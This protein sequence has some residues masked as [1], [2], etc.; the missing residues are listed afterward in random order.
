MGTDELSIAN[1]FEHL[2]SKGQ[3]VGDDPNS[4]AYDGWRQKKWSDGASVRYGVDVKW[5][6]GD[7]VGCA[8]DLEQGEIRFYLNGND[9]DTWS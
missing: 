5:K 3:D 4:C 1:V 7:E 2:E 9:L 6:A 8:L